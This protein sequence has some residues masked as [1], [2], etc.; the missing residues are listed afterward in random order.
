MN[1]L[2]IFTNY[3]VKFNIVW[4]AQKIKSLVNNK[5]IVS[6]DSCIIYRR[7]CSRGADYKGET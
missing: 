5:D 6:H 3:R 7:I 2:E 1:K 4:N